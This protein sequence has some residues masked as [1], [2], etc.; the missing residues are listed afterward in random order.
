M[1]VSDGSMMRASCTVSSSLPAIARVLVVGEQPDERL[2]EDD[3][4]EDQQRR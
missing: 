4:E 2:G 3:A 1:N